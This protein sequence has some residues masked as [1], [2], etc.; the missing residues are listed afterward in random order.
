MAQGLPRRRF[1]GSGL[2]RVLTDL[3]VAD[4][5]ESKQCFA[6]R[7]GQWLDLTDALSLFSALNA[8]TGAA[9]NAVPSARSPESGEVREA[10][11]RVRSALLASVNAAGVPKAAKARVE[12]PAPAVP[13]PEDSAAGFAPY[14]RCYLAHQRD[15]NGSIGPL[16]ARV[17]AA[18]SRQS[19]A[20][21]RLA[22][23]DAVLDK[24]FVARE[25][26]L[27]AT[28]PELLARRFEDLHRAHRAAVSEA[29]TEHGPGAS[30][31]PGGWLAVFCAEMQAVLTAELDFRLQ[32]VAGLIA[33]LDNEVAR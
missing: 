2:V 20:L 7:L 1:N 17:R 18:L 10:F 30:M 4:V 21:K 22:V 27:L 29:Q 8:D 23:L 24:A 6:A 14:R 31:W 9:P 25:R 5:P 3:A 28:V 26:E 33:A 12:W 13:M 11:D 32:P 16:R 15:M 19:P